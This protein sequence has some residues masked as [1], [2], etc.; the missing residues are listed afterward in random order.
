MSDRF[1]ISEPTTSSSTTVTIES[2]SAAQIVVH[3]NSSIVRL[4]VISSVS[5]S[6][7][8]L[9]RTAKRPS[10]SMI[11]GNVSRRM[12]VPRNVLMT[13]KISATQSAPK[14]P[15]DSSIPDSSQ[16]VTTKASA[17]IPSRMRMAMSIRLSD[18]TTPVGRRT[19]SLRG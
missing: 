1:P 6:M 4:L 5:Q 7:N 2:S 3:Q 12:I 13:P 19:T 15:P 16:A 18:D 17:V 10:V 8:A 14:K 11:S 9:I